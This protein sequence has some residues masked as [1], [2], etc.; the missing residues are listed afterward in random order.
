[1]R[2]EKKRREVQSLELSIDN[3]T[4]VSL[5]LLHGFLFNFCA[6]AGT[7]GDVFLLF[8]IH[9]TPKIILLLAAVLQLA[10][11]AIYPYTLFVDLAACLYVQSE[12]NRFAI[13]P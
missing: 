2:Q 3:R 12:N 1:V 9:G 11:E 7:Y 13:Q 8:S 6:K 4:S 10:R 5:E